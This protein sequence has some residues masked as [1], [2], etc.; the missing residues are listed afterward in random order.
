MESQPAPV[1]KMDEKVACNLHLFPQTD[2]ETL[3]RQKC[4]FLASGEIVCA[5]ATLINGNA[6]IRRQIETN[7]R[8]IPNGYSF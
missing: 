7:K 4:M 6:Y 2:D 8:H 5:P 3:Q 1:E